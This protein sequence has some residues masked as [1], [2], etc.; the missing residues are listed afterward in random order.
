[1][2][3]RI[4]SYA[5][6]RTESK[7]LS[8]SFDPEKLQRRESALRADGFEVK[9]VYSPGQARFEIEM[10]TCGIFVTCALIPDI[11]N[12]DLMD[13]FRRYCSASGLIIFVAND[14]SASSSPYEPQADVRVPQSQDPEGI[15]EALRNRTPVPNSSTN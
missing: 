8:L 9:S 1:V 14:D 12:R 3:Q 10:G 15:V 4:A 6:M 7:I 13:L 5:D 2:L 11:V